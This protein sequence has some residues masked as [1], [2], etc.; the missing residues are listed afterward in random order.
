MP[1]HEHQPTIVW[2]YMCLEFM[3]TLKKTKR[4][5]IEAYRAPINTIDG[6][7]R[8]KEMSL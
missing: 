6:S 3:N 2:L 1:P 8:E 4:A 7:K 5:V